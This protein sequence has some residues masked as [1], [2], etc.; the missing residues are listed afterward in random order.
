[1]E[2]IV[3]AVVSGLCTAVPSIIATMS[4][5]KKNQDLMEYKLNELTEHVIK[6][7]G[8]IDRMYKIES[9]VTLIEDNLNKSERK[10]R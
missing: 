9:R 7:N 8:L 4:A 1:M 6:H 3:V 10:E 5:T 2:T